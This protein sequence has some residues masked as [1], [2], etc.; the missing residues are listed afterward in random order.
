MPRRAADSSGYRSLTDQLHDTMFA[1][2][3]APVSRTGARP[4]SR[5]AARLAAPRAPSVAIRVLAEIGATITGL[6]PDEAATR[7]RADEIGVRA[8]CCQMRKKG[9]LEGTGIERESGH[10]GMMEVLRITDTGRAELA[11]RTGQEAA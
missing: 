2:A 11:R 1:Q 4:T 8:R 10:H 9:W 6:T 3:V 7:A 5:R